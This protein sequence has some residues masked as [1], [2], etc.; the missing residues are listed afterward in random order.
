[1]GKAAAT[2]KMSTFTLK[3][4]SVNFREILNSAI[5]SLFLKYENI[6]Y[7]DS[8]DHSSPYSLQSKKLYY[9]SGLVVNV[10]WHKDKLLKQ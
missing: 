10:L 5:I 7:S 6:H 4:P 9:I 1:M 3:D 8:H 2:W